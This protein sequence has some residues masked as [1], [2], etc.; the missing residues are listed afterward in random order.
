MIESCITLRMCPLIISV[1]LLCIG[2]CC[3]AQTISQSSISAF[4]GSSRVEGLYFSQ[5]AGQGS[6]HVQAKND[7]VTLHQGFEQAMSLFANGTTSSTIQVIVYPNPNVGQFFIETDLSRDVA[8]TLVLFDSMGK[9]VHREE[10]LAGGIERISLLNK[11]RPG[12]YIL[13]ITTVDG[14]IG[15]GRIIIN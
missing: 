1:C 6:L 14:F 11:V 9:L 12:V 2:I 4:G 10:L 7:G 15:S 8:Y 3:N 13:R 5:T